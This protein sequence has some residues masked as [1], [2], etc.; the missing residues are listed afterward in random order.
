LLLL[1]DRL[2]KVFQLFAI[3]QRHARHFQLAVLGR[4]QA[5]EAVDLVGRCFLLLRRLGDFRGR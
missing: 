4:E 3:T 2:L 5:K 1:V